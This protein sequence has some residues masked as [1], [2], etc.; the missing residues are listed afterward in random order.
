MKNQL[1]MRQLGR[2]GLVLLVAVIALGGNTGCKSKKKLAREQAAAEYAARVEQAKRD[3]TAILN[4]ATDWTLAEKEARFNTI[5]S[6]NLQDEEVL[7]LLDLVEDKLARE[8]AESVRRAEEERL[9]QEEEERL[10]AEAARYAPIENHFRAIAGAPDFNAANERIVQA[11]QMF[12]SPD[13]PVLI[14]ISQAGGFNDYDRPTTIRKYLDY[15]K[16]QKVYNN[17]VEQVKYD[18]NGKITELEL[19]KR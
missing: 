18:T 10:R 7:R 17:R 8:R 19:I 2:F 9:R 4:D 5:K 15:L 16:D 13:V 6:W 11:L 3:L 14:I 1:F 12:A